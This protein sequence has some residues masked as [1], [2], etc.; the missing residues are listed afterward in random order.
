MSN[1]TKAIIG[2]VVTVVVVAVAIFIGWSF[3]SPKPVTVP[4]IQLSPAQQSQQA[5]RDALRELSNDSTSTAIV[6]LR[7]ALTLDA[8]NMA[9]KAKLT[10][11]TN[12]ATQTTPSA[13]TNPGSSTT[14]A[15]RPVAVDPFSET[16]KDLGT[17]LP[18][19]FTGYSV[20][21]AQV[22]GREGNVG[23]SPNAPD[24]P[25]S[26][27]VWAVH[28]RN[29]GTAAQEFLDRTRKTLYPKDTAVVTVGGVKGYFATDG[30][31]FAW[32]AYRR[33]RYVFE[34]TL[35]AS[36]GS[37]ADLRALSEQAAGAFPTKP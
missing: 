35:T 8:G 24:A 33:G 3:S 29:S 28:D 7:K 36:G 6:L 30:S 19:T 27:I 23:G 14:T 25:V 10:E 37:P 9:A 34:V 13:P 1:R 2:G 32:T 22:L 31:L 11:L 17:L 21:S 4:T 18:K 12:S 26:S 5:Y 16:I 20:G 15:P